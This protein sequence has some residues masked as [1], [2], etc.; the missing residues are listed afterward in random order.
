[1]KQLHFCARYFYWLAVVFLSVWPLS[2]QQLICPTPLKQ[3]G[4]PCT[5]F[6]PDWD[7]NIS[8]GTKYIPTVVHL[9]GDAST[10]S[11][12]DVKIAIDQLNSNF[13]DPSGLHTVV[14]VLASL[15]PKGKCVDGMAVL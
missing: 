13:V 1:M 5:P 10:L 9:I 8:T 11:Y 15:D 2:A 6:S 4:A 3:E 12:L 14:F 7:N